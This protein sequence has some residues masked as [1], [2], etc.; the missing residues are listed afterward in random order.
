MPRQTLPVEVDRFNAGLFTD[1]NPLTSPPGTMLDAVNVELNIDGSIRRRFGMDYAFSSPSITT[2]VANADTINTA[3]T[4]F[5][6]ANAGGDPNVSLYCVQVGQQL[7]IMTMDDVSVTATSQFSFTSAVDQPFSYAVVDGILVIA[8]NQKTP[9]T[10]TYDPIGKTFST[11]TALLKI[12]DLFGVDDSA[13]TTINQIITRPTSLTALHTYNLRNQTWGVPRVLGTPGG[14]TTPSPTDPITD[15]KASSST[16]YPSNADDV[17]ATL[18]PDTSNTSNRTIERFFAT[19]LI[20][21]PLGNLRAPMG[22]FVID[23]LDRGTSR[24]AQDVANRATYTTLTSLGASC[25]SDLTPGGPTV[26]AEYAGRI[27]YGGFSA[28]LTGGDNASPRMSSY[29]LFTQL[30]SNVND[31][32]NCYQEGDPTSKNS[33]DIID[34]DG[35]FIRIN[36]AYGINY[37]VNLADSLFIVAKNG[38]WRVSGGTNNGFTATAYIVDKISDRGCTNT[39]SVVLVENTLMFWGEDG[40]YVVKTNQFGD[41][42]ATNVTFGHI[43]TLFNGITPS[44]KTY[45]KGCYDSYE[46]KVKWLYNNKLGVTSPTIELVYDVTLQAFYL[47]SVQ[48]PANV[49]QLF[50]MFVGRPYS[51]ITTSNETKTRQIIYLVTKSFSPFLIFSLANYTNLNF[52]DFSSTDAAAFTITNYMSQKYSDSTYQPTKDFQRK[53]QIPYLTIY[54]ENTDKGFT[55]DI[56]G[57]LVP[58]GASSCIVQS[59]WEWTDSAASGRWGRPFQGYRHRRLWLPTISSDPF[60]D[61][62]SVVVTRNKLRGSGRVVSLKFST[63][64]GKDFHLYGW[65]M[66]VGTAVND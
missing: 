43:Q 33:P 35:G 23:A 21:N 13:I 22:Y 20:N 28:Q 57:D 64:P 51:L 58:V 8:N 49:I 59:M 32:G 7:S 48:G 2:N 42:G 44:Q 9:T 63:E 52:M 38:V 53:K 26:V 47:H 1:A 19:D 10:I 29:I 54:L 3:I 15:F 4:T 55:T 14:T 36:D 50:S 30:V 37:M 24:N 62:Y 6:W 18:Y 27:F 46:H 17:V 31:L 5:T 25:P 65:S 45:V 60:S 41:W 16:L 61:G 11:S 66:M 56:N 39:N 40:I 12:R 34:T